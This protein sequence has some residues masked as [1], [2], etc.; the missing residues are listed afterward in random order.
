MTAAVYAVASALPDRTKA[1]LIE[2]E[3]LKIAGSYSNLYKYVTSAFGW[4]GSPKGPLPCAPGRP[5][6]EALA[7]LNV[8]ADWY[9][10]FLC[11]LEPPLQG[12]GV[13]LSG[14]AS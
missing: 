14:S 10:Q 11:L 12:E 13:S 6:L 7:M 9:A 4:V 3:K 5:L 8:D 1:E 2:S